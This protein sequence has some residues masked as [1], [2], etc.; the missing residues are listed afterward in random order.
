M[1]VDV[2]LGTA[3]RTNCDSS[4][5]KIATYLSWYEGVLDLPRSSD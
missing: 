5:I 3:G 2:A 1:N 4:A